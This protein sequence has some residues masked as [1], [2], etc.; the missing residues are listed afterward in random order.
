MNILPSA[1]LDIFQH[2]SP[3]VKRLPSRKMGVQHRSGA[4]AHGSN[5]F[6]ILG[7]KNKRF[8]KRIRIAR[9]NN[10]TALV[11][12]NQLSDFAILRSY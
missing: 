2:P 10:E 12:L 7:K 8:R 5:A 3:M 4:L 9:F 1:A 11:L 6:R